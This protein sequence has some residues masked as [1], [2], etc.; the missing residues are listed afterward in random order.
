MEIIFCVK[1]NIKHLNEFI[2]NVN[3]IRHAGSFE[4]NDYYKNSG[5]Y[6]I[7]KDNIN[8]DIEGD[9]FQEL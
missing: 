5:T 3:V 8:L 6:S 4:E 1:E 2:D 9:L 7:A